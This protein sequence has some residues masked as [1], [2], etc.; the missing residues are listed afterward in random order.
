MSDHA[1]SRDADPRKEEYPTV[2]A[3]EQACRALD[4]C[5]LANRKL[6]AQNDIL[7]VALNGQEAAYSQ[8]YTDGWVDAVKEETE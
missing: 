7:R 2:W 1:D 8:G 3:Y 5:K 6:R 4:K